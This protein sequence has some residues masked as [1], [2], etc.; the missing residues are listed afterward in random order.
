MF[1]WFLVLDLTM[2]TPDPKAMKETQARAQAPSTTIW[3]MW[4]KMNI[5]RKKLR[6][7]K[8]GQKVEGEITREDVLATVRGARKRFAMNRRNNLKVDRNFD[9]TSSKGSVKKGSKM[10]I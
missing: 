4:R 1:R 2:D 10:S 9:T 3:R 6:L 7:I 5:K 8:T